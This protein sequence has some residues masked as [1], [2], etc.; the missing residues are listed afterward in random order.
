MTP[1]VRT[2]LLLGGFGLLVTYFWVASQPVE[3]ELGTVVRQELIVE[4]LEPAPG[5]PA[6]LPA[7]PGPDAGPEEL[8]LYGERFLGWVPRE[9]VD[10]AQYGDADLRR[11][12]REDL[13]I[14]GLYDGAGYLGYA[15]EPE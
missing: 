10:L 14:R 11:F 12:I 7:P 1:L 13:S 8:W 9:D 5:G 3:E 15:D 4:D 2:A 6:T